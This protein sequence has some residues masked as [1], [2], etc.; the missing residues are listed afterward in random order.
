MDVDR[1]QSSWKLGR[2]PVGDLPELGALLMM[3]GHEGPAILELASFHR[4]T[5]GDV[6][7]ALVERAF[8]EAGRP[9]L[10]LEGAMCREAAYLLRDLPSPAEALRALR[11]LVRGRA[12]F[13][14]GG[15][16]AELAGLAME[17]EEF[18]DEPGVQR[19]LEEALPSARE[20]YLG[21]IR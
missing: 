13:V 2:L 4:P 21:K 17:W 9:P 20:R 14:Y 18:S 19:S 10:D 7:A 8:A 11:D 3:R 12:E 15:P 5:E 16:L 1:A 6:P